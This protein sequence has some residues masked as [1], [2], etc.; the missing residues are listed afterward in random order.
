VLDGPPPTAPEID[1]SD[2]VDDVFGGPINEDHPY[3]PITYTLTF[4]RDMDDTTV[5]ASDFENGGT[6]TIAVGMVTETSDGVFDVLV[7]PSGSGTLILQITNNA[8]LKEAGGASL[9]TSSAIADDTTITIIAGSPPLTTISGTAGGTDS[10]NTSGNWDNG[11][12]YGNQSAAVTAGL[13]VQVGGASRPYAGDL[14]FGAGSTLRVNAGTDVNVL[15]SA[16]GTITLLGSATFDMLDAPGWGSGFVIYPDVVLGGNLLID[17]R[18][19]GS[20]HETRVFSGAVSGTGGIT[21]DSDNN[22]ILR[23]SAANTFSGGVTMINANSYLEATADGALG[24]GS[25][26]IGNSTSLK[27]GSG[28]SDSINDHASLNLNGTKDGG[29]AAKVVMGSSETIK[30]LYLDG[31]LQDRGTYGAISS[32]ADNESATFSGSGILTVLNGPPRT[33]FLFK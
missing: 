1:P 20:H 21:M 17:N 32:G 16:G 25:V 29:E 26:T 12:P 19:N 8:V 4:D 14:T 28:L 27:I 9:D 7:T 22:N 2:F 3:Y 30:R 33:I 5:E 31:T 10:W 24:I 15:P 23:F 13:L 18:G 11:V 6:A